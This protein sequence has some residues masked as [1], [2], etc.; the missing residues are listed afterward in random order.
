MLT[1]LGVRFVLSRLLGELLQWR[2]GPLSGGEGRIAER[3]GVLAPCRGKG[4]M[5]VLVLNGVA[6]SFIPSPRPIP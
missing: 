6:A 3:Y 2:P 1:I 5:D 4:K